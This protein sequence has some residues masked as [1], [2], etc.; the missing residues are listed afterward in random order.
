MHEISKSDLSHIWIKIEGNATFTAFAEMAYNSKHCKTI[1]TKI[2][3][4]GVEFNECEDDPKWLENTCER[5]QIPIAELPE[6]FRYT[7]ELMKKGKELDGTLALVPGEY[8]YIYIYYSL[9]IYKLMLRDALGTHWG[10]YR[11]TL[12]RNQIIGNNK[13]INRWERDGLNVSI[14]LF[15][16]EYF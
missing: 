13:L 11:S 6:Y 14:Y 2:E 10:L 16:V 15:Y 4:F 3:C 5:E 8:I 7:A 1:N 12:R 9:L